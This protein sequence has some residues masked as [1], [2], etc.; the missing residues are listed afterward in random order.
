[1]TLDYGAIL[2]PAKFGVAARVDRGTANAHPITRKVANR[3]MV[4]SFHA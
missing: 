1:M 3:T 2:S 4:L